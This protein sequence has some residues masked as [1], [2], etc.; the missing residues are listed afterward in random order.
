VALHHENDIV[1]KTSFR[2]GSQA[3]GLASHEP[4]HLGATS[5][6]PKWIQEI[7]F[8]NLAPAG[9]H[10]LQAK[11]GA[12]VLLKI[13]KRALLVRGR[14]G[15]GETLAYLGFS[16]EGSLNID[17]TPLIL[18]RAIQSSP[19]DRLFATMCATLLT[20]ASRVDPAVSVADLIEDRAKPLFETLLG[21]P[22]TEAPRLAVS[23]TS[24][25]EGRVIGHIRIEN[26]TRFIFGLRLRLDGSDIREGR[27]LPLWSDQYFDLLPSEVAEST[28]TLW[29]QTSEP[30][31][32]LWITVETIDGI[33]KQYPGPGSVEMGSSSR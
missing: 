33:K 16:P 22:P 12:Q 23:W 15:K 11:P 32:P 29:Q 28:V 25:P 8:G 20:L 7:P 17:Q 18:D 27:T 3:N 9:F 19:E 31:K 13:D 10:W 26:G 30:A 24:D 6:A 14:Y 5:A 1:P 4:L 21:R 2:I